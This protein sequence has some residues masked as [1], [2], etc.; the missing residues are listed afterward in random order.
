[1]KRVVLSTPARL[2]FGLVDMN[3]E[4]GRIDGGIQPLGHRGTT[5]G[6]ELGVLGQFGSTFRASHW[7]TSS[8]WQ[9]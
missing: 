8:E 2:H 5:L 1:M 9:F 6:T 3:G 7:H 4:L